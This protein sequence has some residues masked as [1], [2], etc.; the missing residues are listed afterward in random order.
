MKKVKVLFLMMA[1]SLAA[2]SASAQN[3]VVKGTV[4]DAA[5]GT[6]VPYATIVVKGASVWTTTE[7]DGTYSIESPVN[8]VLSVSNLGYAEAEINVEG[9]TVVNIQLAPEFDALSESVVI[10]YGVQQ[11]KLLTGSTIQVKGDDLAKL[12]TTSALGALQS[13]S[14]GVQ[15]TQNSGQPG[16]GFKV[17][18]RGIG[19]I[20]DSAPLYVIDGVAGG[21]INVLNPS[22]IES[23]DVL[24]DAASAAIYGARAAN[25]VVLVT[26]R[27]GKEGRAVVSYDG[28]VGAQYIAKMPDLCT[29]QEYMML[30]D[31][32]LTNSGSPAY[33]WEKLLPSDLYKSIKDGSWTGTNWVKE[34]YNKGALTQNHSVNVAGGSADNKFSL[35]F[36]YTGQDGILGYNALESVNAEYRRYTFRVNSD[37]VVIKRNGLDILK[38]G[39]TLN[40]SFGTNSGIAE[41]DIYWNSLHNAIGANPLLPVYAYDA[42]GNITGF[43]DTEAREKDGWKF[44]DNAKHPMGLDY[45]TSRG[46]NT[47]KS[48]SLQA[49]AYAELQPIKNLRI[50]SQVGYRMSGSSSRSYTMLYDLA[51]SQ[52]SDYDELSQSMSLGHRLTWEN[53]A[54][55]HFDINSDHVFDIVAGQS[56]EKWGMGESLSGESANSIFTNDFE[57]AYLSNAKPERL[58]QVSLSGRPSTKGALASFFGRLNYNIK[59]TYLFSATL[60][61]DGSSNFA[62]GHR[63]GIFPSVSAGWVISNENWMGGSK[64]WLD[65]LKIR[66]SWG[67][68]GNA[69]ISN[70]QYLTTIGLSSSAAY[71][72]SNKGVPSTGAIPGTLA[73]PNVSW[74]TSEQTNIGLDA[75]FFNSAFGVTVDG[76]IKNTKD[77]LVQAPI[78]SV[79]GFEAPYVNG[80]DVRNSGIELALDYSKYT[81]EFNWGVKLNGSYNKNVVTRIANAEGIIHGEDDVL[82]QGTGE[83]YRVQEG[84]PIGYFYGYKT[85]GIFQNQ[86]QVDAT[87]AKYDDAKPGDV[88]FVDYDGDGEITDDDRTMIGNPH[89]DFTAGLNLWFSY[90]GFD[91]NITGYGAFGQ[92]IAKSYRSFFD[93][94]RENFTRDFLNCWTGEGT[95]NRYPTLTLCNDRNWSNISEIYIENGDYFKVSNVTL[96]YDFSR[97]FGKKSFVSKARLYVSAQNLLTITK[98]SGMDPEIGYGF[99]E[100]WVSG[101]DLG[102]YPSARTFLVG[103]NLSF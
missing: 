33:D 40:Y 84:Y 52:Y 97:L 14:P 82:S 43:Y 64:G 86:A 31:M 99:D 66:A 22:D 12:S 91:L 57:R 55:Y 29:A 98:Y 54:S 79:Y 102:Y 42:E 103:V 81:G 93:S 83:M 95:S 75:R 30:Q 62:R 13:Q 32:A 50:K 72:Y 63:W 15:I 74:E 4:T 70:F 5:D 80:G 23:I 90:K 51:G 71:Y 60:R 69:S 76:Y 67:Q 10:G 68:N 47:S 44:D 87:K 7:N 58:D 27:Q 35:G 59:E 77:W 41:G 100:D 6:P 38:V 96:G 48:Y 73:N 49:S 94:P 36:S 88:I 89:P 56:I 26:T 17:N 92:Q 20:G 53:T 39:E 9:R 24:K 16:Q 85:A 46:R 11:K 45:Y 19:T 37:H 1:L 28:Y 21:D 8:G 101:I 25:G 78:A 18:I 34:M 3:I 2:L 65:F 61:A